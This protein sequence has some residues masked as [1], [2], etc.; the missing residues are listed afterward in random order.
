MDANLLFR[1]EP[2]FEVFALL[3]FALAVFVC[4]PVQSVF[5][6]DELV[7]GHVKAAALASIPLCW[8]IIEEY[9]SA[10]GTNLLWHLRYFGNFYALILFLMK[11]ER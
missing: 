2:P 10:F 3:L 6:V 1:R 8:R 9:G 4:F 11:T 5:D 7:L